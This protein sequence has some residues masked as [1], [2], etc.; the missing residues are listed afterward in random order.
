MTD[1]ITCLALA[2]YFEARGEPLD[3]QAAI[4]GVVLERVASD[5]Y[6]DEICDVVMQRKQFSAFNGGIPSVHN[7]RAWNISVMVASQVL[8]DPDGNVSI[9]GA[10]HY[11]NTSVAPY[12]TDSYTYIGQIGNHLFYGPVD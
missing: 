12:W 9:I 1:P 11:H 5:R 6:P 10:T 2:I 3:G 4:A 7:E 8:D